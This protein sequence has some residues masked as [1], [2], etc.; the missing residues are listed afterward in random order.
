MIPS[1]SCEA[2]TI[3]STKAV[4]EISTGDTDS[5]ARKA[6]GASTTTFGAMGKPSVTMAIMV[7]I[8]VI[9]RPWKRGELSTP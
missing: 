1:V 8:P 3:R 7:S 5:P 2:G 4:P 9:R 6:I